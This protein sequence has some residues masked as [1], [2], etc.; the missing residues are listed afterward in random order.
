MCLLFPAR[1]HG[2]AALMSFQPATWFIFRTYFSYFGNQIVHLRINWGVEFVALV[3]VKGQSQEHTQGSNGRGD[4][5]SSRA[6]VDHPTLEPPR[7]I[8]SYQRNP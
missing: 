7:S 4:Y 6:P 3:Y 1:I 5:P 2:R 8:R